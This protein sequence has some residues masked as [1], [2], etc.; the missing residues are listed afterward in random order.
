MPPA[1]CTTGSTIT[2]ASSSACALD[3]LGQL[4]DV[5]ASRTRR[6]ARGEHLLR[7]AR[8]ATGRACRRPGRTRSSRR[9]C[10]RGSRRARS[11]A[12]ACPAGPRARW[13]CRHIL[14]ATSTDTEPESA[15]NTCSSPAGRDLAPAAGP[16]ST[17]G[18]WVSPPN[19]TWLIAPSWLAHGGVERRVAVAVDRRP[20]RRHAVDELAPVGEAQPHPRRPTAPAAAARAPG[21]GA[22]GCHTCA[23]RWRAFDA[24]RRRASSR[25]T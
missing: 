1:P 16:A 24:G 21:I 5:G 13:Y 6:A 15:K 8:R 23:G 3:Q 25:P 19:I 17:A 12:G 2:A 4:G 9:T 11:A 7:A 18:A 20:P 10:R 14:I 22:Y